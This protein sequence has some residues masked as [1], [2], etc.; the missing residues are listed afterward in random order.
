MRGQRRA[1]HVLAWRRG[2]RGSWPQRPG[3]PGGRRSSGRTTSS[4]ASRT[5][6]P[7]SCDMWRQIETNKV[8]GGLFPNDGDGKAW[9]DP[10][11]G[12]PAALRGRGL[13]ARR[14]RPL[15]ELHQRLHAPRSTPS[16]PRGAEILTGV[17]IPPDFTTF[18]TQ[19]KQ[20]GFTPKAASVGKALL[21]PSTRSRRWA[22]SATAC[23]PRCGGARATRSRAR[24]PARRPRSWPTP[25]RR[26][27]SKQ[28]TQPIGFAHAHVRG[29][30]R[31]AQP[32]GGPRGPAGDPST[33]S[34][35]PQLD[36]IVGKVDWGADATVP[37][38]VAKTPLV[39][40]QWTQGDGRRVRLRHGHR[41]ATQDQPDVPAAGT[42]RPI[43]GS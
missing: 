19:A 14:P 6:S 26:P 35:R 34:R 20:Q 9:G 38:N 17:P 23:P 31:R 5:S 25:T 36:T 22:T 7:C 1:V 13:H 21:F 15:R 33:P 4:G 32:V 30:R 16:R 27:P 39:G 28:W 40:G 24:S 29:G 37:K 18:W 2:S 8:V 43:P 42:L 12:L 3:R 41:V 11:R 10:E